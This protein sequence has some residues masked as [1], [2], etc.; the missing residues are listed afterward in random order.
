MRARFVALLLLALS[1]SPHAA[2]AQEPPEVGRLF[3]H[4]ADVGAEGSGPFRLPLSS[5]VIS[6]SQPGLSDVRLYDASGREIPWLLDSACRFPAGTGERLLY[7][8]APALETAREREGTPHEP[9]GYRES[10]VIAPPGEAPPRAGWN[11]VVDVRREAF[12]AAIRV[13][14]LGPDGAERELVSTSVYRMQ[15]PTRERVR[16]AVP[17]TTAL[18]LRVEITGQDGYL[19]PL[20]GWEATR[21]IRTPTTMTIPLVIAERREEAGQTILVVTRPPG[22]IP[23]RLRFSTTTPAF[24]RVLR[25]D[26]TSAYTGEIHRVPTVRDAESVE[27]PVSQLRQATF[28]ITIDDGDSPPLE[29]L[30]IEA[31]LSQPTLLFFEPVSLLRFGGGRVRAPHY[32]LDGLQGSW[33]IDRLV[34]GSTTPTDATLG[35]VRPSPT[36]DPAPALSFLHRPGVA[37]TAADYRLAAPLT[38]A[39]APEGASHFLLSPAALSAL[40]EDRSD[41]RIVDAEARQWPYLVTDRPTTTMPLTVSAPS[42]DGDETRYVLGLPV[43]RANLDELRLVADAELVSRAVRVVGID[44]RGDEV[45]L[46]QGML[47]HVPGQTE[48]MTVAL[49]STRVEGLTLIVSDGDESPLAFS[50]VEAALQTSEIFLVAP[51]GEYRVLLGDDDAT[52]ASY[53]IERAREL[54]V[55]IPLADAVLGPLAANPAFH[56]PGLIESAGMQ[57]V[58][59]WVVL[60]LAVL[61]LGVLTWRASREPEVETPA[62][63]K[64]EAAAAEPSTET[65]SAD[66]EKDPE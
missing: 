1:L 12:V 2:R 20:L 64:V 55:A 37:V 22:M 56:E 45:T 39:T 4:E 15:A 11:L 52:P 10:Y 66:A 14:E 48:P 59:L 5:E 7:R 17:G 40:A 23:D 53:D 43:E 63:A 62:A 18:G 57:T 36:W 26:D 32:D 42:R 27:V 21:L 25:I 35:P 30:A 38:V 44:A 9:T 13:I 50:S 49:S 33:M 31:I 46:G 28:T 61:V 8:T 47:Q 16:F 58:G 60:V 3:S 19:E 41:L 51:P 65:A 34:D 6:R 24:A 29:D 54:L